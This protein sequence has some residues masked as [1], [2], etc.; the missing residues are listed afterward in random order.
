MI[1]LFIYIAIPVVLAAAYINLRRFRDFYPNQL[2]CLKVSLLFGH[3]LQI[4]K[5]AQRGVCKDRHFDCIIEEMATDLGNPPFLFLDV[6]PLISPLMIIRSP[7]IAEQITRVSQTFKY[8]MPKA[9]PSSTIKAVMGAHS[10]VN[11]NGED[12]RS[13][14]KRY[15]PGF[16]PK[17][18]QTLLPLIISHIKTF[19]EKLSRAAETGEVIK[20]GEYISYLTMDIIGAVTLDY[21]LRAQAKRENQTPAVRSLMDLL[22]WLP[23]GEN[24]FDE[25]NPVGLSMRYYYQRISDREVMK[26]VQGKANERK[27]REERGEKGTRSILNLSF[28]GVERVTPLLL[29][30]KSITSELS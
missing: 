2:P 4:S 17:Y 29:N 23:K 1:L 9:P 28:E 19:S 30:R 10:M 8:S 24:P 22:E 14:R 27:R 12:W 6:R 5:Y 15:N 20:L 7:E 11:M 26:L 25:I 21:D 16:Q 13:M 18:L 3:I